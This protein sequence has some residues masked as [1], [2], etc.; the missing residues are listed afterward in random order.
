MTDN[1]FIN[2]FHFLEEDS[3]FMDKLE[4]N[5]EWAYRFKD[6]DGFFYLYVPKS[7]KHFEK[8]GIT[9]PIK[10]NSYWFNELIRKIEETLN[11]Q[12]KLR[13]ELKTTP[14]AKG[15]WKYGASES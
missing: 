12:W 4:R 6:A 9:G 13:D 1:S 5:Q 10:S 3:H 11:E 14:L 7:K 15:E 8:Y 2:H